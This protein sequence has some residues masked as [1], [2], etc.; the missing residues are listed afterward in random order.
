[1]GAR[2]LR[3]IQAS[4]FALDT[5]LAGIPDLPPALRELVVDARYRAAERVFGTAIA[6]RADVLLLVGG[7][8]SAESGPGSRGPWF[9]LEQFRRL[10]QHGIPVIWA[11]VSHE[12][13]DW[14]A[15][16][17]SLP[18]NVT[19]LSGES[20]SRV[21]LAGQHVA[22]HCR[23]AGSVVPV[24][25]GVADWNLVLAPSMT[26]DFSLGNWA[27][28][29]GQAGPG[30][31]LLSEKAFSSG[32]PQGSGFHEPGAHGCLSFTLT[33]DEPPR[34][35]FIP[36]DVVRWAMESVTPASDCSLESLR[37][38]LAHRLGQFPAGHSCDAWIVGWRL[39]E[40]AH[41]PLALSHCEKL[42]AELRQ[43][44]FDNG[45]AAWPGKL[46]IARTVLQC[47]SRS[48]AGDDPARAIWNAARHVLHSPETAL[49]LAD[50][51]GDDVSGIPQA[52]R[53]IPAD[54]RRPAV[55]S[56]LCAQAVR[57]LAARSL[58]ALR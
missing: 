5:P 42:L 11:E 28:Y 34:T 51:L 20:T 43:D 37:R 10:A 24:E 55:E 36:T 38:D 22:L 49:D 18:A 14:V 27:D 8:L 31:A 33:G 50:L 16:N 32:A 52:L 15:A 46:E 21:T 44:A 41:A 47:G 23:S 1:M 9:L 6:R 12:L 13:H 48:D 30:R 17:L 25:K 45:I 7:I 57:T 2:A 54:D 53:T 4:G 3:G 26:V 56:H 58:T 35:E 19:L 29:V 40:S 39:E